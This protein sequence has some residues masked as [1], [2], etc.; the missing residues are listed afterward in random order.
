MDATLIWSLRKPFMWVW[1]KLVGLLGAWTIKPILRQAHEHHLALRRWQKRWVELAAGFEYKLLTHSPFD[2]DANREQSIWIRNTRNKVIDEMHFC[3]EAKLGKASYQVP[4]ALYRLAPGCMAR[5]ALHGLPLES[6]TVHKE[7][8]FSS[9]ESIQVYPVRIVYLQQTEVYATSGIV[10]HSTYNDFLNSEWKR[11]DGR[12]YNVSAIAES[13]REL[14]MRLA[15]RLCWRHSLLGMDISG[16]LEQALR[17]RRYR[18]LP[19]VLALALASSK[20][21]L[22]TIVWT[23]LLLRV[24]RIAFECDQAMTAA[25]EHVLHKGESA[26][27]VRVLSQDVT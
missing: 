3:V 24:E 16:L 1:R 9:Y 25:T 7:E 23:R 26:R 20:P 10:W 14:S 21:V 17:H 11:W 6:L 13:R 5:L 18:R 27:P 8:I 15:H 19:G 4:L 12:L 22:T 2:E